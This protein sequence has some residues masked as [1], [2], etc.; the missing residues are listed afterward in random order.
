MNIL[1]TRSAVKVN[2][3]TVTTDGT[4]HSTIP[5]CIHTPNLGFIPQIMYAICSGHDY[6]RN[7]A[8]GQGHFTVNQKWYATFC[9]PKIHSHTKFVIPTSNT[10][11][12]MHQ[13][14]WGMDGH[15]RGIWPLLYRPLAAEN[16]SDG[17]VRHK[18]LP[19]VEGM[20]K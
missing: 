4:R 11:G 3:V 9:H 12:D 13:T 20:A 19:L 14:R 6:F 7:K 10:I 1:E 15:S 18:L 17:I 8:S 2:E 5:K 16:L